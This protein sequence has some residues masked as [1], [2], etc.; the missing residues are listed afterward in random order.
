MNIKL[1]ELSTQHM[2]WFPVPEETYKMA[3]CNNNKS[4][5]SSKFDAENLFYI[6]PSIYFKIIPTIIGGQNEQRY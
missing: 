6:L 3:I 4:F 5:Q 2:K 1:Y